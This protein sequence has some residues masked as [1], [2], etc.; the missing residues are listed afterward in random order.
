MSVYTAYFF[1]HSSICSWAFVLF[2]DVSITN[3]A[4]VN[5]GIHSS[6]WINVFVFLNR[7]QEIGLQNH[8]V[9]LFSIFDKSLMISHRGWEPIYSSTKRNKSIFFITSQILLVS[10]IFFCIGH[11][12]YCEVLTFLLTCTLL[13]ISVTEHLFLHPLPVSMSY[14]DKCSTILPIFMMELF[15]FF[16]LRFCFIYLDHFSDLRYENIF[17]IHQDIFLF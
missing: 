2:P 3:S 7:C 5:G 8:V 1:F 4:V 9:V 17:L 11:S 6:L 12:H 10:P 13:K 14:T 16:L 15:V